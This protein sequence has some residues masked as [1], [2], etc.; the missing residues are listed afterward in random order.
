MSTDYLKTN[1]NNLSENSNILFLSDYPSETTEE[2]IRSFFK[3]YS[4]I[5]CDL[6]G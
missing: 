1:F 3:D 5:K 4:I 6:K 2:D